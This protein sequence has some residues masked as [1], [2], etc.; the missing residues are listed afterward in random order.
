MLSGALVAAN[1]VSDAVQAEEKTNSSH[2][3]SKFFAAVFTIELA[4]N[5]YAHW[6]MPFFR[7]GWNYLDIL[8]VVA[9]L[10]ALFSSINFGPIRYF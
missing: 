8:S 1:F 7:D 6:L 3:E 5:L 10:L 2:D 9:S 4:M